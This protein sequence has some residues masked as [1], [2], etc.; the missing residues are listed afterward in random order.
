MNMRGTKW[1]RFFL[2][3]EGINPYQHYNQT[4]A[5]Q[6]IAQGWATTGTF[7][8]PYF[9]LPTLEGRDKRADQIVFGGQIAEGNVEVTINP[10]EGGSAVI[11][12]GTDTT[13]AQPV[14]STDAHFDLLQIRIKINQGSSTFK[15]PNALPIVI[16]GRAYL[17]DPDVAVLGLPGGGSF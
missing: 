1:D 15:T 6:N 10:N 12:A 9:S 13:R 7:D 8:S 5:S 3:P 17:S 4:G 16:R 2:S 14:E 11:F